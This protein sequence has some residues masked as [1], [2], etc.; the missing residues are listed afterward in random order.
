M[1]RHPPT[2]WACFF[3]TENEAWHRG[4]ACQFP[5]NFIIRFNLAWYCS[6]QVILFRFIQPYLHF[7]FSGRCRYFNDGALFYTYALLSPSQFCHIPF[8][9][10]WDVREIW[11]QLELSLSWMS[12]L[13][14][15]NW[16][17]M[18]RMQDKSKWLLH[19][20]TRQFGTF[21]SCKAQMPFL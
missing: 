3:Q 17:E 20:P 7:H 18:T 2:D 9:S 11:S 13:Q 4:R 8:A 10:I 6:Q 15:L 5:C 1:S 21:S 14:W 12:Q 16:R 19:Q